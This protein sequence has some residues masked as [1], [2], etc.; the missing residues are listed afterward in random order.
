MIRNG[1]NATIRDRPKLLPKLGKSGLRIAR[2]AAVRPEPL[3]E[4]FTVLVVHLGPAE[5]LLP[6]GLAVPRAWRVG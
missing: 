3:D 1:F 5:R 2:T 4:E 6:A